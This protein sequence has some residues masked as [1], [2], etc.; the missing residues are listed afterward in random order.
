MRKAK[1]ESSMQKAEGQKQQDGSQ[2]KEARGQK[3]RR[4]A[5][6]E[7]R[8]TKKEKRK[9]EEEGRQNNDDR[10]QKE[11]ESRKKAEERR[12]TEGESRKTKGGDWAKAGRVSGP[13]KWPKRGRD[14]GFGRRK[15]AI[16]QR[17]V[18][19]QSA[20]HKQAIKMIVFCNA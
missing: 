19:R 20:P 7:A 8:K 10:R 4:K 1:E 11:A 3:T 9:E 15:V 18:V 5:N 16:W 12:E 17:G 13:R 14:L 6:E 2:K